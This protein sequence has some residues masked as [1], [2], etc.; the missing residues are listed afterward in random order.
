MRPSTFF[1]VI[2]PII[3]L[4]SFMYM[5]AFDKKPEP[6]KTDREKALELIEE[7]AFNRPPRI[8]L[9]MN[10]QFVDKKTREKFNILIFKTDEEFQPR[11]SPVPEKTNSVLNMLQTDLPDTDFGEPIENKATYARLLFGN[12]EWTISSI[13]TSNG[14]FSKWVK[15]VDVHQLIRE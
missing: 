12:A 15:K 1:L 4:V 6:P 10:Q 14:Y 9:L 8:S 13:Q 5:G 11:S 2:L 7:I 3:V